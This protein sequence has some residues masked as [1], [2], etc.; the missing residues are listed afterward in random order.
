[1]ATT[2][3]QL[4]FIGELCYPSPPTMIL[5]LVGIHVKEMFGFTRAPGRSDDPFDN[6]LSASLHKTRCFPRGQHGFTK[7]PQVRGI[8]GQLSPIRT[9]SCTL[10]YLADTEPTMMQ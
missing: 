4:C 3:A 6:K 1:M 2:G 9:D 5:L 10:V 8:S 7:V